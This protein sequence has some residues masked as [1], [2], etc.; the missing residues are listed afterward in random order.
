M[1]K[2]TSFKQVFQSN[3]IH[4]LSRRHGNE[5][6]QNSAEQHKDFNGRVPLELSTGAG[7]EI[8]FVVRLPIL[9]SNN[10]NKTKLI[11]IKSFLSDPGSIIVYAC[12][13]LTNCHGL[14]EN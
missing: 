10:C 7:G 14:V 6:H 9:K 11:D 8:S 3:H 12:Q 4:K 13:S 2:V 1:S 5:G